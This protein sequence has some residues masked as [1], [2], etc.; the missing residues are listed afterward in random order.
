MQKKN[1]FNILLYPHANLILPYNLYLQNKMDKP[2]KSELMKKFFFSLVAA[3]LFLVQ[4]QATTYH[5]ITIDGSNNG[6]NSDET[7]DDISHDGNSNPRHAYLTWDEDYLYVGIMDVE[8]DY[9]NMA[10]FIYFDT[11]PW[12]NNGSTNAYAWT[13]F[14]NVGFKADYAV[15]WKNNYGDDYIEIRHYNDGTGNWDLAGSSKAYYLYDGTDTLVKFAVTENSDYREVKIKRSLI[16]NPE[17]LKTSMFTEQ[18]WSGSGYYRYMTWPSEGWTDAYRT[19]GQTIPNYYGFILEENYSL[20]SLVYYNAAFNRWSGGTDNNWS[21]TSNWET[22]SLPTDT[23][24]VVIPQASLI[25]VDGAA[26][27]FDLSVKQGAT[28]TV[29]ENHSLTVNGGLFNNAGAAGL[30]INSS[31]TGNGSLIVKGYASDSVTAQCHITPSRWHSFATPVSGQTTSNLFLNHSPDVWLL[32][33]NENTDDYTYISSLTQDL[34]D[35]HGW[36]LWLGGSSDHVFNF[37]GPLRSSPL[38][39]DNNMIRSSSSTGYNFVGNPYTS[40]IDWDAASG[41]T[42]TNLNNAIYIYNPD[43]ASSHWATYVGGVGTNGGSQYIAMN[44][45]FF[46][47]VTDGGSYPGYGTL[48]MT[49]DV[50]VHNTVQFFKNSGKDNTGEIIRLQVSAQDSLSDETVIRVHPQATADF[51]AQ[52]DAHKLSDF[53]SDGIAIFSTANDKMAINSIPPGTETVSIDFSGP[54]STQMTVS[55]TEAADFEHVFLT[56]NAEGIT[57]DLKKENYT[58]IYR[59]YLHNRFYIHFTVTNSDDTPGKDLLN[60]F[61]TKQHINIINNNGKQTTATI[62]NLLGQKIKSVKFNATSVSVDVESNRYYIVIIQNNS[63]TLTQKVFV[64]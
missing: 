20:D 9:N 18:E 54:N 5:T 12:G 63:Q 27:V 6:W 25:T 34:G 14:I 31:A 21:T 4:V 40:A 23:T 37:A 28:V 51:D 45:G 44:Q 43:G 19:S 16:G 41:W 47:Q 11:D 3:S 26:E 39:T 36:M 35:M 33:Y 61:G 38:G 10:T 62:Y 56:D 1:T 60:A 52:W 24:L 58:F 22:P 29:S 55:L 53:G 8:A 42:K 15:I 7:F 2:A 57:V 50:C 49:R 30:I 64:P 13:E 32:K 46:V 48:K 59:N 17:A